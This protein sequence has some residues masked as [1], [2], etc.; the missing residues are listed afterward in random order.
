MP[1]LVVLD[2]GLPKIDGMDVARRLRHNDDVPILMLT[3]RDAL[4]SRVEGLDAGAPRAAA[5]PWWSV[6]CR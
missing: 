5:P 3:A 4:E 2:L 6:T 1:D